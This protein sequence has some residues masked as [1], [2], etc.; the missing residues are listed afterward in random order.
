MRLLPKIPEMVSKKPK[1]GKNE[2]K[3]EMNQI[4]VGK[5]F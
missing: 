3:N 2:S 1:T 5:V 4:S